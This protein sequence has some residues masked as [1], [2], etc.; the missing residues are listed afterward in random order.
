MISAPRRLLMKWKLSVLAA[1][2]VLA[3]ATAATA[4]TRI[5]TGRVT[6]S[7]SDEVVTSGHVPVLGRTVGPTIQDDGPFTL[8]APAN[9]VTLSIRSIGFKRK[10]V[11]VPAS[12]SSVQAS[13]AR[14]Y[15]QLEAIV[16]TGQATGIER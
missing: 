1:A 4:Q 11:V 2:L 6:D 16:V 7:V 13:L 15:F 10:D 3:S 8:A 14:D 9:E 5:I 12:Q